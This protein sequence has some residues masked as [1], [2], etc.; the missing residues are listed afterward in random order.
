MVG[1]CVE[2]IK[3]QK[4]RRR[5][6]GELRNV[7]AFRLDIYKTMYKFLRQSIR[8]RVSTSGD[9]QYTPNKEIAFIQM[10]RQPPLNSD[11]SHF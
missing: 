4:I 1:M 6:K 7:R 3:N 10:W 2:G 8:K 11:P 5:K 9:R